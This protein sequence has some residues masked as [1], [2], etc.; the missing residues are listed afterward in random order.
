MSSS[1][2][3]NLDSQL[4]S[5][6][7]FIPDYVMEVE[8]DAVQPSTAST[9]HG[10]GEEWPGLQPYQ[11]EPIAYPAWIAQYNEER[12]AKEERRQLLLSRLNGTIPVVDW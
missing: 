10:E 4:D 12:R 8:D 9:Q 2:S 5:D 3:D 1:F 6:I 7:Y 11:D